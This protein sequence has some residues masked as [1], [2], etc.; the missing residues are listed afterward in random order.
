[1]KGGWTRWAAAALAAALFY[2][3]QA[4]AEPAE[5]SAATPAASPDAS[6]RAAMAEIVAALAFALPLSLSDERYS[7]PA[8]RA[9]IQA[10]LTTL[11]T[12][13]DRLQAHASGPDEGFVL[14][15]GT[16]ASDTHSVLEHYE[17]ERFAESRFLLLQ[18]TDNCVACHSRLPD[19]A[20]HPLGLALADDPAVRALPLQERVELEVATR[21]FDRALASYEELFRSPAVSPS[22]LDLLG[23]L[24]GYL[25]VCLR[26]RNDP[27]RAARSFE[28]LA[29]RDDVSPPL[30]KSLIAWVAAL[31]ALP[32]TAT[33]E[34][35]L[36]AARELVKTARDSS[37]FP[38]DRRALVPYVAAS[39]LLHRY[40]S[41]G[42]HTPRELAEAYH[43]LGLIESHVGRSFWLSQTEHFL[44]ASIRTAPGDPRAEEAYALLEEFV[45]AGYTGSGGSAVPDDA[46]I[47]LAALRS[48]IDAAQPATGVGEPPQD[49]SQQ[50]SNTAE[51]P[52][53]DFPAAR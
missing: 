48:L 36:A 32:E 10:A 11:A 22:D 13:G 35:S 21:Q 7:D 15:A 38:D 44:E 31:R 2:T 5:D 12:S 42:D 39:G 51:P 53:V 45:V 34:P 24:D 33:G 30:R 40:V 29:E 6:T 26:V 16:L 47:R 4:A 9:K 20:P 25:E 14:L 3:G 46:R 1:M 18:V 27:A 50:P 8:Q 17:Q 28:A 49:D 37:R 43:L 41:E 52:Q 23:A 19:D